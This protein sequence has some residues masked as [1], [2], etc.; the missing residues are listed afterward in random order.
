[1]RQ[2]GASDLVDIDIGPAHQLA[3]LLDQARSCS[4]SVLTLT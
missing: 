2:H 4:I 1:V 3:F